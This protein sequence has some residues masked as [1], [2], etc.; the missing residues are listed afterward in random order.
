MLSFRGFGCWRIF[1]WQSRRGQGAFQKGERLFCDSFEEKDV[2]AKA[3]RFKN[4]VRRQK[5]RTHILELLGKPTFHPSSGLDLNSELLEVTHLLQAS[6]G[7][8]S[9]NLSSFQRIKRGRQLNPREKEKLRT[10][11]NS[12]LKF[13]RQLANR[14]F[15][16]LKAEPTLIRLKNAKDDLKLQTQL[17]NKRIREL[18]QLKINSARLYRKRAKQTIM[19]K[20]KRIKAQYKDSR[21]QLEKTRQTILSLQKSLEEVDLEIRFILKTLEAVYTKE[22]ASQKQERK[23]KQKESSDV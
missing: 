21:I 12:V 7:G 9:S 18:C 22:K 8:G 5:E 20:R 10:F 19:A 2:S 23:R 1:L 17:Q 15:P 3:R 4:Q 16:E 14:V 11:A 6:D 13:P